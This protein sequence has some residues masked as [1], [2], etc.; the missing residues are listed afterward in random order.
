MELSPTGFGR[1][2]AGQ[3]LV[4]QMLGQSERHGHSRAAGRGDDMNARLRFQNHCGKLRMFH[5]FTAPTSFDAF[6]GECQK[7]AG[8]LQDQAV[9]FVVAEGC[10]LV[11]VFV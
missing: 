2:I 6:I 9:D 7:R 1:G 11:V 4:P 10:D 8:M 3:P 5:V